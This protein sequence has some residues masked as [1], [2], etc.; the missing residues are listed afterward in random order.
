MSRKAIKLL[1]ICFFTVLSYACAQRAPLGIFPEGIKVLL[2]V[3]D[4]CP[5]CIQLS[6]NLDGLPLIHVGMDE[7]N[8]A[9]EPYFADQNYV[10][11]RAF[12]VDSV[13]TISVIQDGQEVKR[14][15]GYIEASPVRE[16]V[17]D[18]LEGLLTP[19]YEFILKIGQTVTDDYSAYTGFL[20]FY[21]DS[22]DACKE[23]A[24]FLTEACQSG[25]SLTVLSTRE[26]PTPEGCPGVY[27]RDIAVEWGVPGVP[28]TV[29]L[30]DGEVVWFDVGYREDFIE[31]NEA[32]LSLRPRK[33]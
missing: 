2:F 7:K 10:V 16:A 13:P 6:E 4:D 11:G 17:E 26:E 23:E 27:A 14:F 25:I 29:Y 18:A 8:T 9:Y 20:V 21:R 32:L 3:N 30:S 1:P 5:A 24:P 33:E 19:E 22:C 12:S 28:A 15:D 31:F